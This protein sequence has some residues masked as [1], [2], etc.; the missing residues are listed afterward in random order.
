MHFFKDSLLHVTLVKVLAACEVDFKVSEN[1]VFSNEGLSTFL[2]HFKHD[3]H[4]DLRKSEEPQDG[5]K[6]RTARELDS[7]K[8]FSGL[9]FH[10]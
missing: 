5:D 2:H 7:P 10:F 9:I 3:T 6:R 8:K 1:D 4:L